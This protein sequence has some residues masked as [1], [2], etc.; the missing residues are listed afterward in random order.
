M[1]DVDRV[2]CCARAVCS[3][4]KREGKRARTNKPAAG[5]RWNLFPFLLHRYLCDPDTFPRGPS[6]VPLH[7]SCWPWRVAAGAPLRRGLRRTTRLWS[8]LNHG[9]HR[10]TAPPASSPVLLPVPPT[11]SQAAAP[12]PMAAPGVFALPRIQIGPAKTAACSCSLSQAILG[13]CHHVIQLLLLT[14]LPVSSNFFPFFLRFS[15][16]SP[17]WLVFA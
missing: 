16:P 1:I 9:S 14:C 10:L 13:P 11:R 3:S 8:A 15:S 6:A 2:A 7:V 17:I 12:C 4:G 5:L